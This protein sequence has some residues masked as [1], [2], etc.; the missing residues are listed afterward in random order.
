MANEV[1]QAVQP[2]LFYRERMYS[3]PNAWP[4]SFAFPPL[5]LR[6][7]AWGHFLAKVSFSQPGKKLL[8]TRRHADDLSIFI[9][10]FSLPA[11]ERTAS[12]CPHTSLH[13]KQN[14]VYFLSVLDERVFSSL[15]PTDL[16]NLLS[17]PGGS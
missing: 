1:A 12:H 7:C 2:K 11:S 16:V 3:T 5:H 8:D 6:L 10:L 9:D 13:G 17:R 4:L 14:L 15:F